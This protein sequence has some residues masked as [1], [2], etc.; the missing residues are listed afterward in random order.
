MIINNLSWIRVKFCKWMMMMELLLAKVCLQCM[1]C[2]SIVYRILYIKRWHLCQSVASQSWRNIMKNWRRNC[3][4][5]PKVNMQPQNYIDAGEMG[6]AIIQQ[7]LQCKSVT[8]LSVEKLNEAAWELST[9]SES[10]RRSLIGFVN[11]ISVGIGSGDTRPTE[12]ICAMIIRSQFSPLAS[13]HLRPHTLV[14]VK[15]YGFVM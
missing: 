12:I 5:Y 4:I 1:R 10:M 9:G 6:L 7:I 14:S 13:D 3:L 11:N 15:R 2:D 8:K